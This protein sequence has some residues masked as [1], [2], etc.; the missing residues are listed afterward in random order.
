MSRQLKVYLVDIL[1]AIEEIES[2]TKDL[3]YEEFAKNTMAVRAVT[4]DFAIIGEAAKQIPAETKKKYN[5]VPWK[6]MAGIR[7][8]VIHGYGYIK[9][10][11]LWDAVK[12]DVP[13]L[14]PMI[15]ELL[16]EFGDK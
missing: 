3:T 1:N 16:G 5:Q 2:F 8:K 7:D 6:Q 15:K 11:V 13:V 4:M 9:L 12:L 14:K 10:G